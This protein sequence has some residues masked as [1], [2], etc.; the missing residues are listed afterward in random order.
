MGALATFPLVLEILGGTCRGRKSKA[1]QSTPFTKREED[2]LR[3]VR[4]PTLDDR[5]MRIRHILVA[6]LIRISYVPHANTPTG[7]YHGQHAI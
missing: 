4:M 3:T 2:S 6:F 1:G 7:S 5:A